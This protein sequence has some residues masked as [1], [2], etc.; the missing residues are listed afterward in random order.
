VLQPRFRGDGFLALEGRRVV[1]SALVLAAAAALS[2]CSYSLQ[3]ELV[4]A[5]SHVRV[6]H[7]ANSFTASG[8]LT[9]LVVTGSLLTNRATDRDP[10]TH[11]HIAGY[12]GIARSL[13]Q[14]SS[15]RAIG[16]SQAQARARLAK[17]V[18]A[19]V[20]DANTEYARQSRIYDTVTEHGRAQNQGP[21]YGFPGG[22]NAS[23]YCPQ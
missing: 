9:L 1:F 15:V 3:L 6:V 2:P 4:P 14:T 16:S 12:F 23:V 10:G 5:I 7:A 21:A 19:L 17:A 18:A 11:A 22:P 8:N 13:A 20:R